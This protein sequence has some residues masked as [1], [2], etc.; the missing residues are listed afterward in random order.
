[1]ADRFETPEVFKIMEEETT[2]S[3]LDSSQKNEY[4]ALVGD[5]YLT[6]P[7]EL[8]ARSE[9]AGVTS[10]RRKELHRARQ[11]KHYQKKKVAYYNILNKKCF[12]HL[13]LDCFFIPFLQ[14]AAADLTALHSKTESDLSTQRREH[15]TLSDYNTILKGMEKVTAQMAAALG[16]IS[17][18]NDSSTTMNHHHNQIDNPLH[19]HFSASPGSN[20]EYSKAPEE[21]NN[22]NINK[23]HDIVSGASSRLVPLGDISDLSAIDNLHTAAKITLPPAL[24]NAAT[25]GSPEAL[26]QH[27]REFAIE[28]KETLEKLDN[29]S[30]FE[31]DIVLNRLNSQLGTMGLALTV[32]MRHN[33]AAMLTLW[34]AGVPP[35]PTVQLTEF[36]DLEKERWEQECT[37]LYGKVVTAM[38]P[39]PAQRKKSIQIWN[40]F[41]A[42]RGEISIQGAEH[43]MQL[44]TLLLENS[45]VS[46]GHNGQLPPAS[47]GLQVKHPSREALNSLQ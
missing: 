3:Y 12:H 45:T 37:A 21:A 42:I 6:A 28:V 10:E 26:L 47:L 16:A 1:M 30:P 34:S 18:P 41:K 44:H 43:I 17:S 40:K 19:H 22:P 2:L 36:P 15:E 32:A 33:Q 25:I 13:I 27:W 24:F 29:S 46:V 35:K 14:S 31:K 9:P 5:L 11:K 38:D 4:S 23:K 20:K 39:T 7:S 8:P